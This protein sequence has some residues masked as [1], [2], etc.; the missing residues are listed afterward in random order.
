MVVYDPYD[1][2][3]HEDPYPVYRALREEAP[4]YYNEE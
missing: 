2:E 1:W 4:A 3:I